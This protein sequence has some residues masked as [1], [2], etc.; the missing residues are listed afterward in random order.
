MGLGQGAPEWAVGGQQSRECL[1]WD[2]GC[3]EGSSPCCD[4]LP[5]RRPL[6]VPPQS[7]LPTILSDCFVPQSKSPD[8]GR[9][10]GQGV[11]HPPVHLLGGGTRAGLRSLASW[12][13]PLVSHLLSVWP[14]SIIASH[15]SRTCSNHQLCPKGTL[16]GH[17]GLR[18]MVPCHYSAWLPLLAAVS[19]T[20]S[21]PGLALTV[22][23]WDGDFLKDP[24]LTATDSVLSQAQRGLPCGKPVSVPVAHSWTRGWSLSEPQ[25][26]PLGLGSELAILPFAAH[27]GVVVVWGMDFS[28]LGGLVLERLCFLFT[29]PEVCI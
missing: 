20:G 15:G 13:G 21:H 14:L 25:L 16:A 2:C 19:G 27:K 12:T 6:V 28:A 10:T 23:L 8:G 5:D 18:D 29:Y 3:A 24:W 7:S 22:D 11:S 1:H 17:T 4:L 9:D 26:H